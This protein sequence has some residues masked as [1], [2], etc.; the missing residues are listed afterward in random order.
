MMYMVTVR[1]GGEVSKVFENEFEAKEFYNNNISNNVI[2][3]TIEPFEYDNKTMYYSVGNGCIA[4]L[5]SDYSY[6]CKLY[7]DKVDM[8]EIVNRLEDYLN[9]ET[10]F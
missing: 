5:N 6:I 3:N 7:T 10:V 1:T 9:S 2:M 4:V 8:N